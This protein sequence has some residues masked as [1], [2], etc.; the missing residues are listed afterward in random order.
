MK[1]ASLSVILIIILLIASTANAQM[2]YCPVGQDTVV[3]Q[4]VSSPVTMS[5]IGYQ[6][7]CTY[8]FAGFSNFS[9][10]FVQSSANSRWIEFQPV[11]KGV[12]EDTIAEEF[13]PH[14]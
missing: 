9:G 13:M 12:F 6:D 14:A 4:S 7:S 2:V 5:C 10:P 8:G 1:N 11:T 3:F